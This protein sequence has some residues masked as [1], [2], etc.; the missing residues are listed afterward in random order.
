[1]NDKQKKDLE[2]LSKIDDG[3]IERNTQKRIDLIKNMRRRVAYKKY[4]AIAA[5]AAL[6]LSLMAVFIVLLKP[7]SP[8]VDE[9]KQIPI[10]EGMTVLSEYNGKP[11]AERDDMSVGYLSTKMP[12][13]V[14]FLSDKGNGNAYGNNKKPVDE[15]IDNDGSIGIDVPEQEMF[16]ARPNQDIYINVHI[17][18][19]D[20]FEILSFTLNGKKYSSYMFEE[21]SDMENLI[22]KFN[23]GAADGI[24]EYT[25]DAIKYIDGTDIKDV[26]MEGERTVKVGVATEK[27]P[28]ANIENEYIGIN[29]MGF[30]VDIV[31]ELNLIGIC[32]GKIYAVVCDDSNVVFQQELSRFEINKVRVEALETNTVYRYAIVACYDALDGAGTDTHVIYEKEFCTDAVDC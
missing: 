11:Q 28:V 14:S 21:G 20:S 4:V 25:I 15:I 2:V 30:D 17:S 12:Y 22:L 1:M 32:Y 5:A 13:R 27:Q 31:D 18:T 23:V 10:Y 24:V 26:I 19:P 29:S 9:Q 16:Y 6:L 7:D 8:V 3:I